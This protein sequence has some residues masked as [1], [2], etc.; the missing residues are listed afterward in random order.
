MNVKKAIIDIE[1]GWSD[2]DFTSNP[3]FILISAQ[4]GGIWGG[5]YK[6]VKD[7]KEMGGID[8]VW[9]CWSWV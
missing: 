1:K 6:R 4:T 3:F 9:V 5:I 2:D 8:R 7:G